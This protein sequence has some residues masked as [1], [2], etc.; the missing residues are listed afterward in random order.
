MMYRPLE[1]VHKYDTD[2]GAMSAFLRFGGKLSPQD[3]VI[4]FLI[5][6]GDPRRRHRE[7]LFAFWEKFGCFTGPHE[8]AKY[9]TAIHVAQT[10]AATKQ[11]MDIAVSAWEET[12]EEPEGYSAQTPNG[13][14]RK[15]QAV[16][17]NQG[18]IT[19]TNTYFYKDEEPQII[20][21]TIKHYKD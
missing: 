17:Q 7:G 9:M 5:D 18:V 11:L 8:K 1:R 20:E 21:A 6:E 4:G 2:I 13:W 10:K 12:I 15:D 16:S 14:V 3:V 19:V